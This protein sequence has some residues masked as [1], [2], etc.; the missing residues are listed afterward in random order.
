M[1][2]VYIYNMNKRSISSKKLKELAS[3]FESIAIILV[4]LMVCIKPKTYISSFSE[5]LQIFSGSVLPAMLPFFIFTRILY[6][7]GWGKKMGV[8]LGKPLNILFNA[9][10]SSGYVFAMS[11]L[12][13][14]PIGAKL[15]ESLYSSGEISTDEALKM[16]SFC[17]GAGP[18]FIMGTIGGVLFQS[19][20]F[21]LVIL[22]SNY[23][24][25]IFNGFLW[26]GKKKKHKPGKTFELKNSDPILDSLLSTLCVGTY[27]AL[28]N[29]LCEVLSR[30]GLVNFIFTILTK[31]NIPYNEDV[32]KSIL[33]GIIEVT[34]GSF[35][36]SNLGINKLSLCLTAGITSFGG[37][38]I[39]CQSMNFL[40]KCNIKS[41]SFIIRKITQSIFAIITAFILSFVFG[42]T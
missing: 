20:I 5:G 8:I 16:C 2:Q 12:G 3:V 41:R 34:K 15:T 14:Y 19:Q 38:G 39:I 37:I 36:V 6:S 17:S 42:I 29:L 18:I 27:I 23:A 25:C 33:F 22:L 1:E 9:P 24:S 31:T 35:T 4:M 32:V 10:S 26:R 30:I 7:L 11:L 13:G 21:A 40:K 28:F